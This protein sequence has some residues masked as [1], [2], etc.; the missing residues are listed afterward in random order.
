MQRASQTR[1]YTKT[2]APTALSQGSEMAQGFQ[3]GGVAGGIVMRPGILCFG[4]RA[5][6]G[7]P[8]SSEAQAWQ[9][10]PNAKASSRA[11]SDAG[12][13]SYVSCA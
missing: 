8:A 10:P 6:M 7:E 5:L 12:N 1:P 11:H 13:G 3:S 2:M 4:Y 9:R